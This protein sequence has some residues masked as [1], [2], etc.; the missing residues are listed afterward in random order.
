MGRPSARLRSAAMVSNESDAP[1]DEAD[2]PDFHPDDEA[3]PEADD[4]DFHPDDQDVAIDNAAYDVPTLGT[5]RQRVKQDENVVFKRRGTGRNRWRTEPRQR[6]NAPFNPDLPPRTTKCKKSEHPG[7]RQ[8]NL[9][10]CQIWL[11]FVLGVVF[12]MMMEK[13]LDMILKETNKHAHARKLAGKLGSYSWKPMDKEELLAFVAVVLGM[14][15]SVK[16]SYRLV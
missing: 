10:C 13:G 9:K 2:D 15:T 8:C 1:D 11:F 16:R 14:G 7:D 4:P 12:L 6:W 5:K 3:D